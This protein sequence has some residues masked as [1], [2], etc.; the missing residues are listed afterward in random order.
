MLDSNGNLSLL[1]LDINILTGPIF[2][3]Y[4]MFVTWFCL[5]SFNK[6]GFKSKIYWSSVALLLIPVGKRVYLGFNSFI[7]CFS[8]VKSSQK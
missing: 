4:R 8:G 7:G 2:L 1:F 3:N 6:K 5:F